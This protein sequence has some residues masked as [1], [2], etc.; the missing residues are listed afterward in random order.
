[1]GAVEGDS[2]SE[3]DEL[4]VGLYRA[5]LKL[6][7]ESDI[8]ESEFVNYSDLREDT[9]EEADEIWRAQGISGQVLVHFIRE[10]TEAEEED[11]QYYIVVTVEEGSS[12]SHALLFSFPTRDISLVDRYRHGENL[13]AEEV[14][15]EASH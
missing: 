6:R 8:K 14:V 9:I 10:F 15:Q 12:N 1:M 11:P 2:L 4:A 3:G 5:M 13:Q 7:S